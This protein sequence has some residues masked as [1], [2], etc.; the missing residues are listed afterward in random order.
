MIITIYLIGIPLF[1]FIIMLFTKFFPNVLECDDPADYALGYGMM[2]LFWPFVL[3]VA[4]IGI[5]YYKFYQMINTIDKH[6][7]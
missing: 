4:S 2:S 7:K 5:I 1:P 3:F 6:K